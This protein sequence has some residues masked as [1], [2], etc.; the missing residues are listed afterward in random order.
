MFLRFLNGDIKKLL[1][2]VQFYAVL[3]NELTIFLNNKYGVG[4]FSNQLSEH[5]LCP[6]MALCT[7][8]LVYC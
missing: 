6:P 4:Y 7:L 2:K 5:D 8:Y 1:A 3:C